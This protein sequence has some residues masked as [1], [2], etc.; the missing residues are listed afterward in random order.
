MRLRLLPALNTASYITYIMDTTTINKALESVESSHTV[1]AYRRA[2][3]SFGE[4][5][6]GEAITYDSLTKYRAH[7][8]SQEKSPQNVNQQLNAIRFYVKNLADRGQ[9]PAGE[10]VTICNVKGLKVKGRKLGK[11]LSVEEAEKILNTPDVSTP[12]GLRDRAILGLLIGAGL[13]RSE[14]AT[15]QRQQIEKRGGRW[16]LVGVSGKHG[17]TRNV[18]IAD[19]VKALIDVWAER[20]GIESGYLFRAVYR[21]ADDERLRLEDKP[22]TP[23]AIFYI[24][25]RYGDRASLRLAPHDCR[26]T[27]A[28]LAFEGDAPVAQIQLALGHA[29]QVTTEN[30]INATQDLQMS[31]SDV[32]GGNIQI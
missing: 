23:S 17:R 20:A 32:L 2:L 9:M 6:K 1:R 16:M 29:N 7:L 12:L 14:A 24:V 19:W 22:L 31:P 27:F 13:R 5:L 10:A 28:R 26:R 3:E 15:L 11:W 18:P 25:E 8:V 21:R 30:Y 4:W